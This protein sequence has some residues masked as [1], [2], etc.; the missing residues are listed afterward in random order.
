MKEKF[1][2]IKLHSCSSYNFQFICLFF[3]FN[4]SGLLGEKLRAKEC[5]SPIF[6]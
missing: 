6:E 1:T 3:T 4:F 5:F 2:M